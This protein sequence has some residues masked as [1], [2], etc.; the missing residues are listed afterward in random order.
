MICDEYGSPSPVVCTLDVVRQKN[1]SVPHRIMSFMTGYPD[2]AQRLRKKKM[3]GRAVARE[4]VNWHIAWF[5]NYTWC[6]IIPA[7]CEDLFT[8]M[9]RKMMNC[10]KWLRVLSVGSS[11]RNK[12]VGIL[13]LKI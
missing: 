7:N 13:Q 2:I 3:T 8:E 1:N 11:P 10:D 5:K 9:T 12:D 6:V 4:I